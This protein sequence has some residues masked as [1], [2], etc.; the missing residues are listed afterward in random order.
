MVPTNANPPERSDFFFAMTVLFYTLGCKVNQYDTQSLK[1]AFARRGF[2]PPPPGTAPDVVV[3]NTCTVTAE[4]DRKGRQAVRRFARLY[5]GAVIAVTGCMPQA[6]PEKAAALP[7]AHVVVGNAANDRLPELVLRYCATRRRVVEIDPHPKRFPTACTPGESFE[8]RAR[9]Y[10]K[11]E[12]GCDRFC[13]YCLIPHARGRVRSKPLPAL[14]EE[15]LTLSAVGYREVVLVGINLTAYGRDIGCSLADAV[16]AAAE[17]PGFARVRLGSMEPDQL[18]ADEIGR[19]AACDKL[20]GHFHLSLQSGSDKVLAAMG[21]PY[22]TAFYRKLVASLRRAFPGCAVT[23]DVMCGY[24]GEEEADFEE[25]LAFMD[26]IGFA[27]VHP[28]CYSPREGTPA[29]ALPGL[30]AE[31][32]AARMARLTERARALAAR[33]NR[34]LIGG[35]QE[36]L[37]ERGGEGDRSRGHTTGYAPVR[38]VCGS[39]RP[40]QILPVRITG[41]DEEGCEGE[42][43]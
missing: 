24:P 6:R 3:V 11:I 41:A 37:F 1:E 7:E 15:L 28:F 12:D 2:T 23:T 4:S 32:K 34:S 40:G 26:E 39:A 17:L 33:Y 18:T 27:R 16:E 29:A 38:L 8:G 19:L 25:T 21:R 43:V 5:P 9:A 36:V 10:V 42:L 31:V 13:R 35:V 20:C 14:R 30:P 22:D